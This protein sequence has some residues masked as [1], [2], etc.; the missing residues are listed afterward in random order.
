MQY[1]VIY[2][3]ALSSEKKVK[4][5]PVDC[6]TGFLNISL[7]KACPMSEASALGMARPASRAVSRSSAHKALLYQRLPH[8]TR[9]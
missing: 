9:E 8:P 4:K 6:S 3:S 5:N 2:P 7:T 1:F